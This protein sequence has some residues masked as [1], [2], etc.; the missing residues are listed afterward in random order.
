MKHKLSASALTAY[1]KSPRSFYYSYVQRLEP[2]QQSTA[3]FDQDKLAGILW[4][5][6]VDRFYHGASE[7]SNMKAMMASWLEQTDGWVGEKQREKLTKAL[8]AWGRQYYQQFSPD[9]GTRN[10]SE[11]RVEN[12]RFVGYLDGLSHE[13]CIHECKSTSR[14][15]QL[16]G[17]LWKVQHSIQ[18]KLY[19]VMANATGACVEFAF[20][21]PPY[22]IFRAPVMDITAEQ[23]I[24]W[25]QELNALAD[26]IYSL[27]DDIN[28][29]PCNSDGCCITSKGGTWMCQFMPLCSEIPGAEIAFM[30]REHR[31]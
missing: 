4:A 2:L 8:E 20:K 16:D 6:F 25:E 29:Y 3:T 10:G 22:Q 17:Q 19:A 31:K 11:L 23:R 18:V 24:L 15:P 26:T 27:G 28:N 5:A 13:R 14:S 7:E 9:D 1:L 30:P 21:D 12:D